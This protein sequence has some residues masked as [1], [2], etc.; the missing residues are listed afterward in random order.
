MI[1]IRRG[2]LEDLCEAAK[3]TYPNEFLAMLGSTKKNEVIDEY[4]VVPATYGKMHATVRLDLVPVDFQVVGLVHSHPS[5]SN[6]PSQA[7]LNVF[8]KTG[9]IHLIIAFPFNITTCRLCDLNGKELEW[10]VIK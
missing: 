3:N 9:K 8:K 5:Y 10:K 2:V 6:A 7:D 4:V 1:K